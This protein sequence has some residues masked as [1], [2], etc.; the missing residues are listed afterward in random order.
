MG[1]PKLEYS[2]ESTWDQS[3]TI[4]RMGGSRALIEKLATLFLRD[5]PL[6]LEQALH[7][8][9]Q[10]DY[11]MT[12]IPIHSLKGTSSN[13]CTRHLENLC[14]E[15]LKTVKEGDWKQAQILHQ[16]LADEYS[17][18]ETQFQAFIEHD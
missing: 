17:K 8:I 9:E 18:L 13:F 1:N 16:N 3:R 7:G 2:A 14:A 11:E 15:L 12:Y 4:S 10:Q 5:T 6:Q